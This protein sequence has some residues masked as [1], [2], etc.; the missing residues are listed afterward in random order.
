MHISKQVLRIDFYTVSLQSFVFKIYWAI[1]Q[2]CLVINIYFYKK[3]KKIAISFVFFDF[4][5]MH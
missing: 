3:L 4:E 1:Y 2:A 5:V